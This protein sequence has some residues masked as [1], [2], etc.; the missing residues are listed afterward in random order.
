VASSVSGS[1]I[2]IINLLKVITPDLVG[3][4]AIFWYVAEGAANPIILAPKNV[5]Y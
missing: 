2:S 3:S 1:Y 4:F 5:C